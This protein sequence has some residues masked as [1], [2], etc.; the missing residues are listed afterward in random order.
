MQGIHEHEVAEFI[1]TPRSPRPGVTGAGKTNGSRHGEDS[2]AA[3][4]GPPAGRWIP[5][6]PE[7]DP[8]H[9]DREP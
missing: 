9:G 7:G 4:I 5:A 6:P 1:V 8:S 3:M 2:G